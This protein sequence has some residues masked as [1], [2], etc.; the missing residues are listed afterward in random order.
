MNGPPDPSERRRRTV[1]AWCC[2]DW[3]NSG[4]TTLMITVFVVYLQT[5]VFEADRWGQTGAIVWAWGVSLSMLIGALLSPALGALADAQA[6][7]R[8]W[9]A[10]T[11]VSG[12][13]ACVAM[14]LLPVGNV[15]AITACFLVAN[16]CLELSLTV[17]NGFL[18]EIADDD[19]MNRVSS[20]GMALGYLGGGVLLLL[21]IVFL[22]F[23]SRLGVDLVASRLRGCILATGVWW[24]L[25]T[26]PTVWMLNDR[27]ST[28]RKTRTRIRRAVKHAFLDATTTL[29]QVRKY[30]ALA[31][32][33]IAF[34]FFNDGVQTVISQS[35]TFA[36]Q[37]LHFSESELASVILMVQFLALPGAIFV[38]LLADMV[39]QKTALIACLFVWIGLLCSAWFIE[40]KT[41]YWFM[42]AVVA[43]VLG[44]TQA[45]S[46]AIVGVL[47][48]EDQAAKFF[49]FFN[50]SGKAT[51]FMGTFVFGAIIA[52]TG[53]S[54]LA[55]VNLLIFFII[56]L[57]VVWRVDVSKGKRQR[58]NAGD[59]GSGVVH[60]RGTTSVDRK[61]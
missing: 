57:A 13:C 49:G 40:S 23:G 41:A 12:G 17:Y 39:G 45:V 25:F 18:P 50:L 46:R 44:G 27:M 54:R 8:E 47:A 55:V 33:L 7:K 58:A 34:L 22:K 19:Q 32:F 42:A 15:W 43:L 38:G 24:I 59:M 26:L 21:A 4:Y 20:L 1:L 16:L 6:S 36:L 10:T 37:E 35:S 48:P 52:W 53:S 60:P 2:Y 30:T 11:A 51:S 31:T 3:A 28:K 9:L 5:V 29:L 14:A 61:S 56:G